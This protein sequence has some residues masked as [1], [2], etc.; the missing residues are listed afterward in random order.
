MLRPDPGAVIEVDDELMT[1]DAQGFHRKVKLPDG[2]IV[3]QTCSDHPLWE[4]LR[5][6]Q[7]EDNDPALIS[8]VAYGIDALVAVLN[9]LL[10]RAGAVY[11]IRVVHCPVAEWEDKNALS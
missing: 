11:R 8:A 9:K 6:M 5:E 7:E 1:W 2:S 3:I 4:A 10:A